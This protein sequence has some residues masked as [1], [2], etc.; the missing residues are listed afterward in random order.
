VYDALESDVGDVT[1]ADEGVNIDTS[2]EKVGLCDDDSNKITKVHEKE[3][4]ILNKNISLTPVANGGSY[5]GINESHTTR[6]S[7]TESSNKIE[8]RPNEFEIHN[9]KTRAVPDLCKNSLDSLNR[10]RLGNDATPESSSSKHKKSPSTKLNFRPKPAA[11]LDK[12]L[13]PINRPRPEGDVSPGTSY[14]GGSSCYRGGGDG[15]SRPILEENVNVP[16]KPRAMKRPAETSI[17]NT[18]TKY[19]L[20]ALS[21]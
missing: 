19:L 20:P 12:S 7:P 14:G 2:V 9:S 17:C 5:C 21:L 3:T 18:N 1:S 6:P 10:P 8:N 11:Y 4:F 15:M 13:D 16:S